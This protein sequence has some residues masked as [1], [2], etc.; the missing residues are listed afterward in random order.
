MIRFVHTAD[1]HFGVENYGKIDHVTGIHSRLLDFAK[2]LNFCID[3][4]IE[5]NVDFFLFCGDAYKTHHPTQT[6]QR[7][8][9]ESFFRLYNRGIPVVIIVGNHDHP[10]SFGKTHALNLFGQLP[11]DG[12]YVIE[13]PDSMVLNT[14]NGPVQIV[15]IPWPTRNTISLQKESSLKTATEITTY[16]AQ[17]VAAIIKHKATQLDQA[18]PAVLAAHLTVSTGLFSGSEK[19]AI[20]GT[21]PILLPSQL[22]IEPFDYVALGHLHRFQQL[23]VTTYPP[24]VYAGSVERI[25][26]GERK[27][28]KGFCMVTLKGKYNTEVEFIKTPTRPFL[29]ID[30]SLD[31]GICQTTQVIKKIEQSNIKDAIVKLLYHVPV[32]KQDVVDM[33]KVEHALTD[34]WHLA[35]IVPII[36]HDNR[37][38]RGVVKTSMDFKTALTSYFQTKAALKD[39]TDLL[40]EKAISLLEEAEQM[41]SE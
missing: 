6:Q 34:A 13:K 33:I 1:I 39:R 24:I 23:N 3:Y 31:P 20:Y 38:Q 21:D 29:Y 11:L 41:H 27:E 17:A 4:A 15:G 2:A 40:L 5:S 9:F 22:A 18:M 36:M 32:G 30:I 35:G 12:F 28:E 25:D 8:L 14:K 10:L 26:F 16:I 37:V 7:L 19:R